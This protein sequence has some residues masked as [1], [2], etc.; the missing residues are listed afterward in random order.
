MGTNQTFQ[1]KELMF[2]TIKDVVEKVNTKIN[3][4]ISGLI[5]SNR[6]KTCKQISLDQK[7]SYKAILKSLKL[8]FFLIPQFSKIMVYVANFIHATNPGWLIVDETSISKKFAKIIQGLGW[9]Y[10][11]TSKKPEKG[12]CIVVLAW[13]NGHI[14]LPIAIRFWFNKKTRPKNYKSKIEIAKSLLE[15]FKDK[16]KF[17]HFLA[18]GLYSKK[19][20]LV[21]L[22]EN[23][24]KFI[25]RVASNRNIELKGI[26]AQLK[27]HPEMKLLRNKRSKVALAKAYGIDFYFLSYKRKNVKTNEYEIVYFIANFEAT[28]EQYMKIY[29]GR[30]PIEC[31]FRTAK[32][33]LGLTQCQS[34]FLQREHIYGVFWAYAYL[35]LCKYFY[36][37]L[38][39][40]MTIKYFRDAKSIKVTSLILLLIK[41]LSTG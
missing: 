29:E 5:L 32:Q 8:L 4:Y 31:M 37:H 16:I 6:R 7:I 23:N 21:F 39:V 41:A 38:N 28:A 35:Q 3:F 18:D 15:Q 34:L 25:M 1:K 19:Q 14:T 22:I 11:G 24:I 13:S 20:L 12:L 17:E 40:E 10:N 9:V 26:K 36:K 30:W 33:Y 27:N 2:Y